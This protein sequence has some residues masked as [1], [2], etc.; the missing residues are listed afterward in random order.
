MTSMQTSDNMQK[1]LFRAAYGD[2]SRIM[3]ILADN[4]AEAIT[5]ANERELDG[6]D[7]PEDRFNFDDESVFEV[8]LNQSESQIIEDITADSF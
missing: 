7:E 1:K 4:L 5:L 2:E 6:D 8:N 3:F